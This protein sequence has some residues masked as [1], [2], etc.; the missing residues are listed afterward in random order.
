MHVRALMIGIGGL[1]LVCGVMMLASPMF[2]A[3]LLTIVLVAYV[4]MITVG[5]TA[6]S[7]AKMAEV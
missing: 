3:G 5:S 7:M 2:A 6:R 1:T 4:I